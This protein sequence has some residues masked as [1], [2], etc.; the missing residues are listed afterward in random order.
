MADDVSIPSSSGHSVE[1][2]CDHVWRVWVIGMAWTVEHQFVIRNVLC[3][4]MVRCSYARHYGV[5]VIRSL[6]CTILPALSRPR[7]PPRSPTPVYEPCSPS[8]IIAACRVG[9][10]NRKPPSPHGLRPICWQWPISGVFG[11]KS[12]FPR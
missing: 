4:F 5:F 7:S 10:A 6:L 8:P 9:L 1:Q 2:A 11:T 12:K 3:G